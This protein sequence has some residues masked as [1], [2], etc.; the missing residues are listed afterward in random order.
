MYS[1]LAAVA[2]F[3]GRTY[4][5]IYTIHGFSRTATLEVGDFFVRFD[6]FSEFLYCYFF[7]FLIDC[8]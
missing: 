3:V 6:R 4:I 5:Y 2:R 7:L 1:W 8:G